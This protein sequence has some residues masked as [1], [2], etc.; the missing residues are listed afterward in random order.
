MAIVAVL[1]GGR[2]SRMGGDKA[3]TL[4]AA[5][6]LIDYALRC[7]REA[8]LDVCVVA[9]ATTRLPRLDVPVLIEP[10]RPVHPICGIVAALQHHQAVVALPCDMPMLTPSVLRRLAASEADVMLAVE[11]QPFPALYTDA[12]LP[13][14]ESALA[15]EASIRSVIASL[16]APALGGVDRTL[17]FSVNSRDD[18]ELA[19]RRLGGMRKRSS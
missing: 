8:A 10:D 5:V 13:A 7:A 4:L 18:L 11:G 17:L 6:P 19:E 15:A 2:G 12:T 3:L 1:A 9:K 16:G 14:L